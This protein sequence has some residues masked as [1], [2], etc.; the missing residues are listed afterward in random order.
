MKPCRECGEV[1]PLSE[2][3]EHPEMADGHLN[4]CKECKRK[5]ARLRQRTEAVRAYD[6]R[7]AK[8]PHRK[9]LRAKINRRWSQK[10]PERKKAHSAVNNA[11]RDGRLDKPDAC[12]DCG[13][14]GVL[15]HGH[16]EDYSQP[17]EVEWLCVPCH[18][19]RHPDY[20]AV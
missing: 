7:R 9:E 3:Y 18:G 13:K 11:V 5:Y 17:L 8:L 19:Q 20:V 16:H 2:F 1:K 14:E 4:F 15:L 12:E 6:R 10:H